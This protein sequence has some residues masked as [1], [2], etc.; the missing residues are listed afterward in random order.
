MPRVSFLIP[1]YNAATTMRSA[2][3]SISAQTARD[4]E[5]AFARIE[6][7]G[8]DLLLLDALMPGTYPY[9]DAPSACAKLQQEHPEL[10]VIVLTGALVDSGMTRE[11]LERMV[12]ATVILKED[13][14][15]NPKLLAA[16]VKECLEKKGK[17]TPPS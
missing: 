14:G 4:F 6:E 11:E 5:G 10:P 15:S 8:I 9:A 3:S 13:V 7:G 17:Q 2:L 12:G 16:H 1:C